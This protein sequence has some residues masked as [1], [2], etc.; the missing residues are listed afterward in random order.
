MPI[1]PSYELCIYL[2]TYQFVLN[3][4]PV[5]QQKMSKSNRQRESRR[6]SPMGVAYL[7][8]PQYLRV[9]FSEILIYAESLRSV[10]VT[11]VS[12]FRMEERRPTWSRVSPVRSGSAAVH[13]MTSAIFPVGRS[14][15][16]SIL[17]LSFVCWHLDE[18]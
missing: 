2:C 18:Q 11:V 12:C 1:A 15:P 5:L 16:L 14:L 4:F 7:L 13:L 8:E 17:T 3:F 9:L 6:R 10:L